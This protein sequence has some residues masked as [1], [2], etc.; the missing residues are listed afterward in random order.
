MLLSKNGQTLL[1]N[2]HDFLMDENAFNLIMFNE[3][4]SEKPD[5][6]VIVPPINEVKFGPHKKTGRIALHEKFPNLVEVA[7]N[8]IKEHSF[9][10]HGRRRE[11]T[12][13]GKYK[14]R[15]G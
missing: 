8:F 13:T 11:T 14:H 7:T 2:I 12:G 1:L 5:E 4:S 6:T 9:S 10:A 15:D 3:C